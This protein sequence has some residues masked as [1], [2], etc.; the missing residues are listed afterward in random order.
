MDNKIGRQRWTG[1]D[2]GRE[3]PRDGK[4]RLEGDAVIKIIERKE[5]NNRRGRGIEINMG[6]RRKL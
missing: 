5:I 6:I 4:R 3:R 2:E 1:K